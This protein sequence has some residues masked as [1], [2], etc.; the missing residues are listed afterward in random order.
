MSKFDKLFHIRKDIKKRIIPLCPVLDAEGKWHV[1]IERG[2]DFQEVKIIK[3]VESDYFGQKVDSENDVYFEFMN[4]MYQRATR[5]DVYP[6]LE[7]ITSDMHNLAA[8]FHK[9]ELFHTLKYEKGIDVNRFIVTE[10]E[11]VFSVCRSLFDLFQL[12]AKKYWGGIKLFDPKIKKRDLKDSFAEMVLKGKEVR[13][14]EE[15][16]YRF[17]LPVVLANFYVQEANFFKKIRDYRDNIYHRGLT[18]HIIFHTP[19]G[20]A[21][22]AS[23]EPF[24]CFNVWKKET[25]LPNNLAPIKPIIAFAVGKTFDAMNQ[26]VNTLS[27]I[28]KF[29]EEIAPGYFLFMR[30][31]HIHKLAELEDYIENN[32]WYPECHR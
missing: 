29:P 16:Q 5:E 18:P 6:A 24:A 27:R 8:C 1:W 30:G 20:F 9:I 26:Y 10:I 2:D 31:H 3:P 32:P 17:G 4:F 28:I 21:V 19:K 11:Y 23:Y 25:F 14:A 13:T 12:V 22:Q 7:A 15:L